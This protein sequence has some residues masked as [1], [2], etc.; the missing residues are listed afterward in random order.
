MRK[1][2]FILAFA[3]AAAAISTLTPAPA[4]ASLCPPNY[5]AVFCPASTS[6]G[7][8]YFCCPDNAMCVCA[9]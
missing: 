1:K 5:Y 4:Q 7:T 6:T 8:S 9:P 3:L 2:L